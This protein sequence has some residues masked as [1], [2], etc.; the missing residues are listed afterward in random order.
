MFKGK[1]SNALQSR[2]LVQEYSI[3]GF[4]FVEI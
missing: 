1:A 4:S 3:L 2:K